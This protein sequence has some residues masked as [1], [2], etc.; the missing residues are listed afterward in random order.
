MR[1]DI[2]IANDSAR[3]AMNAFASINDAFRLDIREWFLDSGQP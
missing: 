1:D 2:A 3:N